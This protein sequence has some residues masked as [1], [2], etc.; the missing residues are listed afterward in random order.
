MLWRE[1]PSFL[2]SVLSALEVAFLRFAPPT[3]RE[4]RVSACQMRLPCPQEGGGHEWS[5][6]R[7]IAIAINKTGGKTR[8]R[9]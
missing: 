7:D 2:L 6:A 3:L 8:T 4:I 1:A 9:L 5:F